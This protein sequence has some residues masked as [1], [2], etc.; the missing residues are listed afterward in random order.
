MRAVLRKPVAVS[1]LWPMLVLSLCVG[2]GARCYAQT[3]TQPND[4]T[5]VAAL[6][7]PVLSDSS[8]TTSTAPAVAPPAAKPDPD[9]NADIA[10]ELAAMKAR[11]EQLEAELKSRAATTAPAQPA[12]SAVAPAQPE[13]AQPTVSTVVAPA[14]SDALPAP[15][16][17]SPTFRL[18]KR[19]A[20]RPRRPCEK[21]KDRALL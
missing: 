20:I 18:C 1:T 16:T 15:I 9:P 3:Q 11:I 2:Q 19:R 4:H 5:K 8:T 12:V 6:H 13:S 7:E 21:T 17:A 14:K 10:R